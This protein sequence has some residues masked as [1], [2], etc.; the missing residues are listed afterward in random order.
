MS[1]IM[2]YESY[3]DNSKGQKHKF[4]L[5]LRQHMYIDT[6]SSLTSEEQKNTWKIHIMICS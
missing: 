2:T 3:S 4:I 5:F 1:H 6:S